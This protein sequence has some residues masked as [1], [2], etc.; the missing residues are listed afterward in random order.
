MLALKMWDHAEWPVHSDRLFLFV[1]SR[2]WQEFLHLGRNVVQT[3]GN[4]W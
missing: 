3:E 2:N 4:L 1:W